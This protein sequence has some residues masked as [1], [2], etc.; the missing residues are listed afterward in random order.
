NAALLSA[1]RS[2]SEFMGFAAHELKNP[3]TP[4]KGYADIMR[5]GALGEL[6]DQQKNFIEIIHSNAN[7][8]ETI[9]TDL[10]DAARL[11]GNQF[12]VELA[13][14]DIRHAVIASLQPFVHVLD[15][16]NQELIN[17]VPEDLPLV[18]G[19]ESRLIQVITNLVSNAHKYSPENTTITIKGYIIDNYTDKDGKSHGQMVGIGIVDQGIG[20]SE[21]DLQKLFR[22]RYFRTE[23]AKE[24]DKGTG[25][26]MMLTYG[27]MER[28]NGDILVESEEDKGST[29]TVI[30]PVVSEETLEKL[31]F[32][33]PN[34]S[35][36]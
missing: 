29:F 2:K 33:E 21:E 23:R 34:T 16:K 25:L 14:M 17:D 13:P 10:R 8:M 1:N 12:T 31:R 4:I 32:P 6:T 7:R 15:E 24:M 27:I 11:E 30:V 20:M 5:K 36:D 9:I 35:G 22:E 28:H 18:M 3:L 26:G 19:D